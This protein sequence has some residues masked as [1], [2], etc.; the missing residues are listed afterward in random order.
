M[1]ESLS[2]LFLAST[3]VVHKQT[4]CRLH[5]T[6]WRSPKPP[7]QKNKYT[8]MDKLKQKLFKQ[9]ENKV[10]EELKKFKES[11]RREYLKNYQNQYRQKN[12]RVTFSLS[13]S[14]HQELEEK[15]SQ[16]GL[17]V[18]AYVKQ[19]ALAYLN[20]VFLLPDDSQVQDLEL[21]IRK[22]GNNINQV[23][24]QFH[25]RKLPIPDTLQLIQTHLQHLEEDI[26]AAFREPQSLLE[27]LQEALEKEPQLISKLKSIIETIEK[28]NRND[29]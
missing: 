15:A 6:C 29:P 14:V 28:S 22:I 10:G 1:K 23:V 18:G 4:V 20:Q 13:K 21:S 5:A 27:V 26:T 19:C 17:K 25:K 11:H 16:Q 8:K 24:H 2:V 7:E 3:H 12:K 9:S